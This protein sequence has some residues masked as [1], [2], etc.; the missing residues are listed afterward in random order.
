MSGQNPINTIE[1]LQQSLGNPNTQTYL[2][3]LQQAEG[4]YTGQ[5]GNPY[6]TAFGGGQL[7]DLRQHPKTLHSF[8]QTDGTPNKTSAAGAYQ[9]LGSTWDDV[10]GKLGLPDFGPQSQDLAAL[11]LMRRNG[12]LPHVLAG[13]FDQAMKKDGKTWASLPSSPYA[14]PKRSQGFV[15]RALNAA[16]PS[17][18]AAELPQPTGPDARAAFEQAMQQFRAQAGGGQ[19]QAPSA[20]P[21]PTMPAQ[22]QAPAP[23][24]NGQQQAPMPQQPGQQPDAAGA[25]PQPQQ[26]PT[27]VD[28][29]AV[30][31]QAMQQYKAGQVQGKGGKPLVSTPETKRGFWN[32]IGHQFGLTGRYALE[33]VGQAAEIVT[34]PV[35][36]FITDPLV[37]AMRGPEQTTMADLVKGTLPQQY[38]SKSTGEVAS[39]VA[40]WMGLPKPEG[41]FEEAVG[42]ASRAVAGAGTFMGGAKAATNLVTGEG[43]RAVLGGLSSQPMAQATSA[44][45]GGGAADI[46]R[47]NGA[48]ATGQVVAGVLGSLAPGAASGARV[49]LQNATRGPQMTAMHNAAAREAIEAGYRLPPAQVKPSAVNRT[50]EKFS[51]PKT[52]EQDLGMRNQQVT[53][54]LARRAVGLPEGTDFSPQLLADMRREAGQRYEFLR[55]Q[56]NMRPDREF[57]QDLRNISRQYTSASN[58]FPGLVRDNG[59]TEMVNSLD[60]RRMNADSMVS[61]I[62][63]LREEA[64]RQFATGNAAGGRA[65]RQAATALEGRFERHLQGRGDTQ[66]VAQ[67]RQARQQIA[68]VHQLERALTARGNI[69][70]KVLGNELRRGRPMTG[71]LRT[72]GN[73]AQAFSGPLTVPEQGRMPGPGLMDWIVPFVLGTATGSPA[74]LAGPFARPALRGVLSSNMVQNSLLTPARAVRPG[75]GLRP[76]L[77]AMPHVV[78]GT[79]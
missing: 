10:S 35:R 76:G 50:A 47:H 37:R 18:G 31:E 36:D 14:Q 72:I 61:A 30:F 43:A 15:E 25:A 34:T 55:S 2:R 44:A 20:S 12:S 65:A 23:Q 21:Q 17:A 46:A 28:P 59:V 70:A 64:G 13:N 26:Q 71:E 33:G 11:E 5:G 4:T 73:T 79:Q 42:A 6:A 78:A 7:P 1:Q 45:A 51:N 32:E 77:L 22:Q 16:I 74:A 49:A 40:D 27:A 53:N 24:Q 63:T 60:V 38:R 75:L 69:D 67:F 57:Q 8:T 58:S 52:L 48:S 9:F 29:R 54:D 3:M 19:P 68:T 62:K 41:K 39:S 56:G 66:A